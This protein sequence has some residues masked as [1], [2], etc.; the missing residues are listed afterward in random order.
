M[1]ADLHSFISDLLHRRD[2]TDRD[3]FALRLAEK[4]ST[5]D[6]WN[7]DQIK[8]ATGTVGTDLYRRQSTWSKEKLSALITVA[9]MRRWPSSPH[10]PAKKTKE[11]IRILFV[12]G[13][14]GGSRYN[15]LQIPKEYNSIKEALRASSHGGALELANPILAATHESLVQAYREHPAIL[16]FAGHGNDRSLSIISDQGVLV[17]DIPVLVENL[18]AILQNFP[19]RLRLCVFNTCDSAAIAEQLV[20]SNVLDTAIGWPGTL[21]DSVAIAF[22]RVFYGCLA[23]G[24]PLARSVALAEQAC[25]AKVGPR[26]I[27]DAGIDPIAFSFVETSEG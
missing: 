4:L 9:I 8:M 17:T 22:S 14:R 23:D 6:Q 11:I 18:A 1:T 15:Q 13:D 12:A 19:L 2:L 25:A 20:D 21:D 24:L 26:L 27:S 7:Y 5:V 10:Q 3:E 16:H